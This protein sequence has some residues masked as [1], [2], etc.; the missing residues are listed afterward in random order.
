MPTSYV[1]RFY[2]STP[3]ATLLVP[4]HCHVAMRCAHDAPAADVS[5]TD[6][7]AR[8]TEHIPRLSWTHA[9]HAACTTI[10]ESLSV[11][12]NP[13]RC[14]NDCAAPTH[15]D[16]ACSFGLHIANTKS[17]C[18]ICNNQGVN[19]TP[20]CDRCLGTHTSCRHPHPIGSRTIVFRLVWYDH[21]AHCC[22]RPDCQTATHS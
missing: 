11:P 1:V 4:S 9:I 14:S 7:T 6:V 18:T 19:V 3:T 13:S 17:R 5:S 10:C 22:R 20:V 15:C 21:S 16:T 2:H 12:A 8:L